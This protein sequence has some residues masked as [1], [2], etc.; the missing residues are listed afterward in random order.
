[1]TMAYAVA[2]SD[3]PAN[4]ISYRKAKRIALKARP[5]KIKDFQQMQRKGR[6]VFSFK[7]VCADQVIREVDV[8]AE[9][10]DVVYGAKR[11]NTQK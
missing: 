9:T 10:G 8:D 5:G 3:P 6:W 1:M 2:S 11:K 4:A 7:I